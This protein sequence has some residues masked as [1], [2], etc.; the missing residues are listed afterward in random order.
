MLAW[1]R[2]SGMLVVAGEDERVLLWEI[3]PFSGG[4]AVLLNRGGLANAV[5]VADG[6]LAA[7][8]HDGRIRVWPAA[9]G[10]LA[11]VICDRVGRNLTLKKWR[12][13]V[14]PALRYERTC[15]RL[16]DPTDPLKI[17]QKP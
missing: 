4:P 16:N 2:G 5:A 7:A 1:D 17:R 11:E 12:G 3:E 15:P 13:F 8:G 10:S 9:S 14:G 6:L